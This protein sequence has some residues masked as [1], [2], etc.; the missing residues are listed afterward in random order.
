MRERMTCC[1]TFWGTGFLPISMVFLVLLGGAP[2]ALPGAT[3]DAAFE[4]PDWNP[5]EDAPC[6]FAGKKYGAGSVVC[7]E[8][9]LKRC[10]LRTGIWRSH[11]TGS[12]KSP[13]GCVYGSKNYSSGAVVKMGTEVHWCA[14][15]RWQLGNLRDVSREEPG[16]TSLSPTESC[17]YASAAYGVSAVVCMEGVS[18]R[19][20]PITGEWRVELY[21]ECAQSRICVFESKNFG[22]GSKTTM[23]DEPYY[24]SNFGWR[25]YFPE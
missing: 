3:A 12:C 19:C 23:L 21:G 7:M 15:D 22:A 4:Y 8:Q 2:D 20:Q 5:L 17:I 24:C 11:P 9:V 13:D 1:R 16:V 25:P 14:G 6:A 18:Y 10:D